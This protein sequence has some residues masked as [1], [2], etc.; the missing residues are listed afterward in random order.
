MYQIYFGEKILYDP[1]G[2]N[3][4]DQLNIW[5]AKLELAASAAGTLTFSMDSKHPLYDKLTRMKGLV[6]VIEDGELIF[7]GRIVKETAGI[8]KTKDV[9]AEGQL[10]CLNDSIV[11][12]YVFPDDFLANT[13]YQAAAASG[14]VI[15]FWLG[16]LLDQHNSQVGESQRIY[17]GTVTMTDPNNYISRSNESYSTT[18]E[19]ITGKL[20]GSTLGGYLLV[21][22]E[23]EK[24]YLDYLKDLTIKNA[25]AVS[26]AENLL[27]MD[28]ETDDSNYYTAI[29]PVGADGLTIANLPDGSIG[30]GLV[31]SGSIIYDSNE[32]KSFGGR[33]T[34]TQAWD[35]VTVAENLQSKAAALLAASGVKTAETITCK[36]CD[37]HGLDGS[38][39]FRVGRWVQVVS[40]PHGLADLY[41]LTELTIDLLDP[42]NTRI[43]LGETRNL[44]TSIS[45]SA[46][47]V[48]TAAA[49]EV[50]ATVTKGQQE[51][52]VE[53]SGVKSNVS[54]LKSTV[55]RVSARVS[56]LE[57]SIKGGGLP[58]VSASDE[59]KFLRVNSSGAWAAMTVTAAEG[60]SF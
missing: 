1:R 14:N 55:N 51:L 57:Q 45:A 18:W 11:K 54:S 22:Y 9:E 35:D 26:F 39:S 31:K 20:S 40:R 27:D 3:D 43:T 44:S 48:A 25:Q 46:T 19:T 24:T 53:V 38:E 6:A 5:D 15:Q 49:A 8:Y 34:T 50:K 36:A 7:R 59:G 37:L 29:L 17:L 30:S 16:W 52:A 4:T 10:A 28:T 56:T 41:R 12:P 60:V 23:A 58:E 2:A 47:K 21:R 33:I 13:D 32:E 42:A